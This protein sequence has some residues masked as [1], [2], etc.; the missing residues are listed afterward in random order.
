MKVVGENRL[1]QKRK[2]AYP[3]WNKCWD[4]TVVPGRVLQVLIMQLQSPIADATMKIE[5]RKMLP[6][7]SVVPYQT[8]DFVSGHRG[9]VQTGSGD[10][11]LDQFEACGKNSRSSKTTANS[12]YAIIVMLWPF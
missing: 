7:A 11:Y 8:N 12:R 10:S 9:E 6:T 2:T 5:V 3:E 4:T 1:V